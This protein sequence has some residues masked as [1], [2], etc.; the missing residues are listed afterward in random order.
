MLRSPWRWDAS[1]YD[2]VMKMACGIAHGDGDAG[3]ATKVACGA[4][5][6]DGDAGCQDDDAKLV[7]EVMRSDQNPSMLW[8]QML[9][10][11]NR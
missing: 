5:H 8:Y 3:C 1:S 2:D 11:L 9:W 4:T 6:G 7:A 10:L